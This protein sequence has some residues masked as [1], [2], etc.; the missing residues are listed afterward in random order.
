M[1]YV[2]G[3]A[4]LWLVGLGQMHMKDPVSPP[5]TVTGGTVV[6]SVSLV[7]GADPRVTILSGEE[8]FAS[9]AREALTHWQFQSGLKT[10]PVLVVINFRQP[11]LF[12]VDASTREWEGDR[13]SESLP[14]PKTI[15]EPRYPV[16][17]LGEGSVVFKV[18]LAAT[19]EIAKVETV[20]QLGGLTQAGREALK[21]WH[22]AP[23]KDAAGRAIASEAFVVFVFRS[24]VLSPSAQPAP[25]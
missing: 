2:L 22:F 1:N 21:A 14:Y 19:G 11:A 17:A 15:A 10:N 13:P 16:N 23:A 7:A 9:S 24:P 12:S 4:T 5:N 3:V 20:K 8:P 6:A 18:D 25:R